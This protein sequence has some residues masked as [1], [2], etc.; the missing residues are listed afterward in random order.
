MVRRAQDSESSHL[1]KHTPGFVDYITAGVVG[2]GAATA[3]A[4]RTVQGRFF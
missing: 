3:A 4:I 2:V 1:P